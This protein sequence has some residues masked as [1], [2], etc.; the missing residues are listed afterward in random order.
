MLYVP[1]TAGVDWWHPEEASV[2]CQHPA[3]SPFKG[4]IKSHLCVQARSSYGCCCFRDKSHCTLVVPVYI[5][6][7]KFLKILHV[8]AQVWLTL[9]HTVTLSGHPGL[10]FASRCELR[11]SLEVS[12]ATLCSHGQEVEPYF[13]FY[14]PDLWRRFYHLN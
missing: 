1:Y 4:Q 2:A 11:Q 3:L 7:R 12:A 9:T 5:L 10:V 14:A 6:H 8:L 13:C